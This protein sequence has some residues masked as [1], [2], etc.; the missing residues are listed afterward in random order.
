MNTINIKIVNYHDFIKEIKEIRKDVFIEE[1]NVPEDVE[2]DGL[3]SE[4]KH[5]LVFD[6]GIGI[7]TG[8]MLPDGHI[9]RV[10]VYRQCRGK[11]IGKIIMEKL[12]STAGDLHLSEVWLSSQYHA[13]DFY[14][15]L[16]FI[17]FGEIYQDAGIDHI[18]MKKKL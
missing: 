7:G 11:G 6:A 3:D 12:I 1:Q 16:G 4:A 9:G 2:I 17:V 13:R 15:K 14:R 5:V 10:A 18:N 8:R